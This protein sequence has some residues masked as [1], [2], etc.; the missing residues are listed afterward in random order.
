MPM[1]AHMS[2]SFPRVR[3]FNSLSCPPKLSIFAAW[4]SN[5]VLQRSSATSCALC[6]VASAAN[7]SSMR[8][9]RDSACSP[10]K[11]STSDFEATILSFCASSSCKAWCRACASPNC[12]AATSAEL[13]NWASSASVVSY[14][15]SMRSACIAL[16]QDS[17]VLCIVKPIAFFTACCCA[18]F[19]TLSTF[20]RSCC[21]A[22]SLDCRASASADC[23]A[24]PSAC[25][26]AT[27]S[28]RLLY[29]SASLASL[30][31]NLLHIACMSS[32][33]CFC[34]PISL[35]CNASCL[36]TSS[37]SLFLAASVSA[38]CSASLSSNALTCLA[39]SSC[40]FLRSSS[41]SACFESVSASFLFSSS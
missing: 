34:A 33:F 19:A 5:C 3:I 29:S 36:A 31:S 30:S 14:F 28:W 20:W 13:F 40:R 9:L 41:D 23:A 38:S 10:C 24:C 35:E 1:P 17:H 22:S 8:C 6:T 16:S 25:C 12:F 21:C 37:A 32:Y 26:L 11:V 39:T 27:S 2:T 15:F 18:R 7:N 4:S